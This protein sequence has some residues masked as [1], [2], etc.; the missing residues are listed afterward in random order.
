MLPMTSPA[1]PA[2][3][4]TRSSTER[5]RFT[6]GGFWPSQRKLA[7]ALL[8]ALQQGMGVSWGGGSHGP[9][10]IPLAVLV[11]VHPLACGA[12][13]TSL[14]LY[15]ATRLQLFSRAVGVAVTLYALLSIGWPFLIMGMMNKN[16]FTASLIM[17]SPAFAPGFATA[18]M[19]YDRDPGMMFSVLLGVGLMALVFYSSRAGYD[20][21]AK[22]IRSDGDKTGD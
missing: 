8:A 15:L 17:A 20:E 21:P 13:F 22:L 12:L 3:L 19:L 18:M 2:S 7:L 9:W 16:N 5:A 10:W 6:F 14:G 11:I 4:T 1:L